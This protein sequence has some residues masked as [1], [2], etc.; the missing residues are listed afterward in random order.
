MAIEDGLVTAAEA[1]DA[2]EAFTALLQRD[3]VD[4]LI[5]KCRKLNQSD[6]LYERNY[7]LCN[8]RFMKSYAVC[9]TILVGTGANTW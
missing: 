6:A 1:E 5:V 8:E 3:E 9:Q 2:L 4:A 7:D